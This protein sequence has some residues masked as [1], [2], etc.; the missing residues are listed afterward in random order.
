MSKIFE[1]ESFIQSNITHIKATIR[2]LQENREFFS[3]AVNKEGI[4]FDPKLPEEI[5]S[6]FGPFT[7]F[8]LHNYTFDSIAI[9]DDYISFEAGFGSE[10][11]ASRLNIPLCAILQIIV[12]DMVILSNPT[13]SLPSNFLSSKTV[14]K[15][16]FKFNPNN[17]NFF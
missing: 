4:E 14:S 5:M 17:K 13:A 10:N 15:N 2:L 11:I 8:A 6:G 16:A 1:N 3:I 7:V 9:E 12:D